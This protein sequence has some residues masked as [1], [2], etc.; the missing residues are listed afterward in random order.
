MTDAK[1]Q[2]SLWDGR[3]KGRARGG[4][5]RSFDAVQEEDV[6][7]IFMV[8]KPSSSFFCQHRAPLC[9]AAWRCRG[10][11]RG[12]QSWSLRENPLGERRRGLAPSV[13]ARPLGPRGGPAWGERRYPPSL[14]FRRGRGQPDH[15]H[16]LPPHGVSG[17]PGELWGAGTAVGCRL[18]GCRLDV[19]RNREGWRRKQPGREGGRRRWGDGAGGGARAGAGGSG[20]R[21]HNLQPCLGSAGAPGALRAAARPSQEHF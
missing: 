19:G 1:E 8:V 6:F 16:G 20:H 17:W 21:V 7:I 3:R 15:R 12:L 13:P 11:R 4:P 18:A 14:A 5:A 10:W 2:R 9:P